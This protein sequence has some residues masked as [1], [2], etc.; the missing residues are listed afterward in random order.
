MET[1]ARPERAQSQ[2]QEYIDDGPLAPWKTL[3]QLAAR[4][5]FIFHN[6]ACQASPVF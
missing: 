3:L 1:Q 6:L 5:L 4:T 2:W